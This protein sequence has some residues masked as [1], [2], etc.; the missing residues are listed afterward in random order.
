MKVLALETLSS[1]VGAFFLGF[2]K[3]LGNGLILGTVKWFGAKMGAK[4]SRIGRET[5]ARSEDPA[6]RVK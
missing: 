3:G 6:V 5:V 4:W 2:F 1:G